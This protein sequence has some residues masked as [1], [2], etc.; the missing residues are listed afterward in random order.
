M[1]KRSL[2]FIVLLLFSVSRPLTEA[3]LAQ[4]LSMPHVGHFI[5]KS[6]E[7]VLAYMDAHETPNTHNTQRIEPTQCLMGCLFAVVVVGIILVLES[8]DS[9]S[10]AC[11]LNPYWF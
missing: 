7:Y 2:F 3:A 9:D 1:H 11:L 8:E 6:P 4:T 5:G 10:G